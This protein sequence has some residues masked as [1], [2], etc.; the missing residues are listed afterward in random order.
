M[1]NKIDKLTET[2]FTEV[3]GNIFENA[4]WIAKKLYEQKPEEMN[5]NPNIVLNVVKNTLNIPNFSFKNYIA[6]MDY[7]KT[8]TDPKAM[9][10][11]L[12]S[13]FLN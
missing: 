9:E 6:I 3:F 12:A 5:Q 4:S 8:S 2:E 11:I 7:L 10:R 1:F 13:L